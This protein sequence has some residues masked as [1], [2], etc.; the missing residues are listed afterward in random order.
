MINTRLRDNRVALSRLKTEYSITRLY[1]IY[2]LLGSMMEG[3]LQ[4]K[5]VV[6]NTLQNIEVEVAG[7]KK[8]LKK[9]KVE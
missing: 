8:A 2:G 6:D 9:A 4:L 3:Q 7:L 5:E 1:D